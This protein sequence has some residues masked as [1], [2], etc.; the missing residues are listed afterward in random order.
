METRAILV[1][2][3]G[4]PDAMRFGEIALSDPG[5]GE[6]LLRQTAIAVNYIDVYHR[7]GLYPLPGRPFTPGLE[8]AGIVEKLGPGV[9]GLSEGQRVAYASPPV[10]AYAE[11]RLMPA[12]RLVPLPDFIDDV[13]AAAIM[14][15]GLT[16]E[17]LLRRTFRVKPG[18]TVLIHAAAG[19]VG[20]IACQW[21]D[22]L[23]ARVIGTVGSE[24][25]ADIARASGCH[26][27]IVYTKEDFHA[28]VMDITEGRGVPV[29]YD[30]VGK[31]TFGKSLDCLSPLGTMVSFGQSSGPVPPFDIAVLSQ[32]GSLFLTRPTIMHYMADRNILLEA[33]RELFDRVANQTIRVSV[34]RRYAL[35]DAPRAHEDL[36]QRKTTGSMVLLP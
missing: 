1:D 18:D 36:E 28:R 35:W 21:A 9:E 16:A 30:S 29:V 22:S 19:G 25:K 6:V 20:L 13:T 17:Y 3:P 7:T 24:E 12:D 23:G 15:K 8:A 14:T 2:E 27:P 10:G 33:A 5:E 34:H 11:A 31:D 26:Y 32:K 4:D